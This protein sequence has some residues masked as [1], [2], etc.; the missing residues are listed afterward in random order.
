MGAVWGDAICIDQ[1]N[2]TE[3]NRQLLLMTMAWL[4]EQSEDS[5]L[6]MKAFQDLAKLLAGPPAASGAHLQW[7]DLPQR[8]LLKD[9]CHE[10][11]NAL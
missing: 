8:F 3:R 2:V 10:S 9:M 6:A 7:C 11:F 5:S 4:E 1:S